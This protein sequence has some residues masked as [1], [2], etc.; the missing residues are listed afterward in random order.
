[1][2]NQHY[3][4]APNETMAFRRVDFDPRGMHAGVHEVMPEYPE[5]L[6]VITPPYQLMTYW[7]STVENG[8]NIEFILNR[9]IDEINMWSDKATVRF[10]KLN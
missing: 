10:I 2:K 8:D 7:S 6:T 9:Q 5:F 4:N 1:M 3:D